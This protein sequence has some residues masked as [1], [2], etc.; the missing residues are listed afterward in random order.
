MLLWASCFQIKSAKFQSVTLS[1]QKFQ[2]DICIKRKGVGHGDEKRNEKLP[3]VE[4]CFSVAE[5]KQFHFRRPLQKVLSYILFN[6]DRPVRLVVSP[7]FYSQ[8]NSLGKVKRLA[9]VSHK[10]L[11]S[12]KS[13]LSLP[14]AWV[15]RQNL[16]AVWSSLAICNFWGNQSLKKKKKKKKK[17]YTV[18]PCVKY[19]HSTS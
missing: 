10:W 13:K 9:P 17:R 19:L 2:W 16:Q 7:L 12:W 18:N 1:K 8:F 15:P 4:V 11:Q 5:K 6:P 14:N 3:F